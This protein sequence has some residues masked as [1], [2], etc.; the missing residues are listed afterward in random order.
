MSPTANDPL[1]KAVHV[2]VTLHVREGCEAEFAEVLTKFA[3]RSLDFR[4][5]TGVLLIHP[6]PGT[7]SREFGV[8]RSFKSAEYCRAFYESDMYRQYKAE[9]AH[10]VESDPIIRPLTGLEAFFRSGGQRLPPKWKMAL[11]TYFGVVPA[12]VFWSTTLRPLLK[13]FHW[14]TIILISNAAVVIT[15]AW[16]MMPLLTKL[17]HKWLHAAEDWHVSVARRDK[18][19]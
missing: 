15:L 6:V 3:Q 1:E 2:A 4:G 5:A 16:L 14:L 13:D 17:F 18:R 9:S 12:V 8:M 7:D 19:G 10:L 11:L